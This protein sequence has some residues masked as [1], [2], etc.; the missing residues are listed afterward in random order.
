MVKALLEAGANKNAKNQVPPP[1]APLAEAAQRARA[2]EGCWN[3]AARA[4]SD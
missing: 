2:D 3:S 1:R 4:D